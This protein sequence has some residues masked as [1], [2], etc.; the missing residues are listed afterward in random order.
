VN[1]SLRTS[2]CLFFRACRLQEN[3]AGFW[4]AVTRR[5]PVL[6]V[7]SLGWLGAAALGQAVQAATLSSFTGF[8]E[9]GNTEIV[10][11]SPR[12]IDFARATT[13]AVFVGNGNYENPVAQSDLEAF[14]GIEPGILDTLGNG[15]IDLGSA[16]TQTFAA[17]A[18]DT[19]AFSLNFRT[20]EPV[21]PAGSD[22][23][24]YQLEGDFAFLSIVTPQDS[25][26]EELFDLNYDGFSF[27]DS[28]FAKTGFISFTRTL[29]RAGLY[30][31]GFGVTGVGPVNEPDAFDGNPGDFSNSAIDVRDI[32]LTP[33]PAPSSTLGLAVLGLLG[34]GFLLRKK[35]Q[36]NNLKL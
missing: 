8:D 4:S 9:I 26:V 14:L 1:P 27:D 11:A 19:L 22:T 2:R 31:V 17:R 6:I 28:V 12:N 34:T 23:S 33:V 7:S 10:A 16:V 18:G 15:N 30:T 32:E 24:E 5:A 36:A 25:R 29:P 20:T 3:A 13:E 21:S 35:P